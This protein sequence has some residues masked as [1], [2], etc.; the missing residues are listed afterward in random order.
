M[1]TAKKASQL[2]GKSE[3]GFFKKIDLKDS[4]SCDIKRHVANRENALLRFLSHAEA[5]YIIPILKEKGYTIFAYN[6]GDNMKL[7]VSW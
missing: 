7:V 3:L 4:L 1:M 5:N 2:S 6:E